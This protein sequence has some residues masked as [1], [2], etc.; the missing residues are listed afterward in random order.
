MGR[1]FC[2]AQL[3]FAFGTYLCVSLRGTR[4]TCSRSLSEVVQALRDD[5]SKVVPKS[6]SS[7]V[8]GG[9]GSDGPA[10]TVTANR[11]PTAGDS[12]PSDRAGASAGSVVATGYNSGSFT[13]NGT[14][15]SPVVR[16]P[17]KRTPRGRADPASPD[18]SE[19]PPRD[20]KSPRAVK[21]ASPRLR[22]TVSD[23]VVTPLLDRGMN[24][25]RCHSRLVV[26]FRNERASLPPPPT[27][28]LRCVVCRR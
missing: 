28:S 6:G 23:A 8:G 16:S 9:G 25:G 21:V 22:S 26:A 1:P 11:V 27:F 3:L 4:L 18:R 10:A 7:T 14:V 5:L 12:N 24:R 15:S 20:G 2:I 19:T 13:S 17:K